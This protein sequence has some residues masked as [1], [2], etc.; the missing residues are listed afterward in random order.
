VRPAA[1]DLFALGARDAAVAAALRDDPE[2]LRHFAALT[3]DDADPFSR[4]PRVDGVDVAVHQM[5]SGDAGIA[6]SIVVCVA[7]DAPRE[8]WLAAGRVVE[9]VHVL[10]AAHGLADASPPSRAVEPTDAWTVVDC[11]DWTTS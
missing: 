11:S 6:W 3:A 5:T 8:T 10:A 2:A 9:R 4:L 7:P 1:E